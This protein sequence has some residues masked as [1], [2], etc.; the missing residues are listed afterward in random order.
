VQVVAVD[1]RA[2][3]VVQDS[4]SRGGHVSALPTGGTA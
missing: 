4:V 1:E 2:V 3:D